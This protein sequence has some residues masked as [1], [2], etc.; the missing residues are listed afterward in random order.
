MIV[1]ANRKSGNGEGDVVLQAFRR[2]LNPAQVFIE[3]KAF[4]SK[5][6][7]ANAVFLRCL[8]CRKLN[9]KCASKCAN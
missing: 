8:I 5:R 2:V 1:V 4:I 9:Q 3:S 7:F 6:N